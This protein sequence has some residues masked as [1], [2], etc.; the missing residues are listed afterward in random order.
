MC[1]ELLAHPF[2]RLQ[3][4]AE[5]CFTQDV[6]HGPAA[7]QVAGQEAGQNLQDP[8]SP[9]SYVPEEAAAAPTTGNSEQE[10]VRQVSKAEDG[11]QEVRLWLHLVGNGTGLSLFS[12]AF[13]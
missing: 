8:P 9:D 7:V 5:Q 1:V 3:Y 13:S 10:E 11:P 2:C 12:K 6:T 4:H